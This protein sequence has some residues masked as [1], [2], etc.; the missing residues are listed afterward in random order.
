MSYQDKVESPNNIFCQLFFR[1]RIGE[2]SALILIQMADHVQRQS[3]YD[4]ADDKGTGKRI[5]CIV[6]DDGESE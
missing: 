3:I 2:Y 4:K 5:G 1:N 6:G